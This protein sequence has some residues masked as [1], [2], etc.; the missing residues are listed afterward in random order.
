MS[1]VFQ[2]ERGEF[3]FIINRL[4]EKYASRRQLFH[5]KPPRTRGYYFIA[6]YCGRGEHTARVHPVERDLVTWFFGGPR[7]VVEFK[8]GRL[9]PKLAVKDHIPDAPGS[10]I[11]AVVYFAAEQKACCVGNGFGFTMVIGCGV[12]HTCSY[13]SIFENK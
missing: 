12:R 1:P 11:R 9:S 5:D 4:V 10:I 13:T 7:V 8:H 6:V 3:F 2:I